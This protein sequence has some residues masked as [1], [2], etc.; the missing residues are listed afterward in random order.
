MSEV[1]PTPVPPQIVVV[2]A[3]VAFLTAKVPR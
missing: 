2:D 3:Q 1:R